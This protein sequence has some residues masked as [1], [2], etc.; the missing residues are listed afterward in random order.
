MAHF[1]NDTNSHYITPTTGNFN[2]YP[3]L[4]QGS[5]IETANV[6]NF[7]PS[8]N[9]RDMIQRPGSVVGV[10][11]QNHPSY[12]VPYNYYVQQQHPGQYPPEDQA[13][14][15]PA[16]YPGWGDSFV[17]AANLN[18]HPAIPDPGNCKNMFCF[19]TLIN[20][21]LTDYEQS[22]PAPGMV[23]RTRQPLRHPT[24]YACKFHRPHT[25]SLISSI[26]R[27]HTF[28]IISGLVQ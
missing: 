28:P 10:W 27:M 15:Q 20:R 4:S 3:D 6:S 8:A 24:R 13:K 23:T 18:A 5:A 11:A 19:E 12:Q 14:P 22:R 9:H 1:N 16:G 2:L 25:V 21:M 7:D 26:S 17:A